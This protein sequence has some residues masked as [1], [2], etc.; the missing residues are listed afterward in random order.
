MKIGLEHRLSKG[1]ETD[2]GAIVNGK[3]GSR[4]ICLKQRHRTQDQ[5]DSQRRQPIAH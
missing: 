3:N 4:Q 5:A 2:I 1:A